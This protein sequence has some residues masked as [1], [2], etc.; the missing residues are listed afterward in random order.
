MIRVIHNCK[1]K[2]TVLSNSRKTYIQRSDKL[3]SSYFDTSPLL[4]LLV[5]ILNFFK[6]CFATF[7]YLFF[8]LLDLYKLKIDI[9]KNLLENKT[10][11]RKILFEEKKE[12]T[13]LIKLFSILE[14]LEFEI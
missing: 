9:N 6:N 13:Y 12:I 3:F 2:Q 10:Y 1:S 7:F 14:F 4:V 5:S 11:I 8:I